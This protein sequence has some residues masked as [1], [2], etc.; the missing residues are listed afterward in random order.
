MNTLAKLSACL[1][2][3]VLFPALCAA[4][5]KIEI[6]TDPPAP[7]PQWPVVREVGQAKVLYDERGG[8]TVVQTSPLQVQGDWRSGIRLRAGFAVSGKEVAKPSEVT[9]SFYSAAADRTYADNRALKIIIDGKE[10][11]SGV[12]RYRSGNTDGEVFL[13]TLT[14]DVPYEVFLRLLN[15]RSVKVRIGPAEFELGDGD[16]EALRDLQR[17]I[18]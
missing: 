12:A 9:L 1:C 11:L 13:I 8:K 15:S 6:S 3:L 5:E 14:Q 4:Q 10:A 16:L 17:I 18:G 7:A 2:L